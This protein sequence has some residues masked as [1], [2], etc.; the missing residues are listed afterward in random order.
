M[1]GAASELNPEPTA[2]IA[3]S[4]RTGAPALDHRVGRVNWK[5][6][7]CAE[8]GVPL[9]FVGKASEMVS[10]S[11][12]LQSPLQMDALSPT[13]SRRLGSEL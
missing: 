13:R 10:R 8:R 5:A 11:P 12:A 6:V 4:S 9:T 1:V 2:R 7:G 3:F